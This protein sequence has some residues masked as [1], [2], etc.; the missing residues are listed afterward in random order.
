MVTLTE[1]KR[2]A[3]YRISILLLC[4]GGLTALIRPAASGEVTI[5]NPVER[6]PL[7]ELTATRER[8]L[9]SSTRRPPPKVVAPVA[10]QEP[11]PP[12]PPPPSVV[13]LG[14]MSENGEARAAIRSA[15]KRP[16]DK[17]S[18]VRMGDDVGGWKVER[19]EPRRLVLTQGDRSVDFVLFAAADKG[20]KSA[21]VSARGRQER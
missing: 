9:F 19:I 3:G 10:R 8:P 20:A 4:V 18:R 15:D 14:I 11:P 17:V 7:Q 13:V 21:D 2:A 16:A 12:P 6:Q 1:G 5:S